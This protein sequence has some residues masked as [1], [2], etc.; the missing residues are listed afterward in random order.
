[1][2]LVLRQALRA[3]LGPAIVLALLPACRGGGPPPDP[4]A[5]SD[6]APGALPAGAQ[7]VSLLGDTLYPPALPEAVEAERRAHFRAAEE[8]LSADP[9]G[10]DALIWMGRRTAYLGRY[11]E[12]MDVFSRALEVH[13]GDPRIWR[14]RGHRQITVR[15]FDDAVADLTR[16]AELMAGRPDEVEPDGLPN[17]AGIPTS[18]LHFNVWYHLGLAHYLK[19]DFEAAAEAYAACAEASVHPD[20][21]V[22][23][24]YW[25]VMTLKRLGQ[26]EEAD[27]VLAG[28]SRDEEVIESGGY[29]ELL[30]LHKGERTA[31]ALVGPEGGDAT[32]ESTTTGYGV[33][34]WHLLSGDTTRARDIF[35]RVLAGRDQWA[36]FGYIASEAEL[37]R[38]GGR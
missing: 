26:H 17:A 18:T 9:T 14:H 23:T 16:A 10:A 30:L 2:R 32:L 34:A 3:V 19:G 33:G 4:G 8:S 36:A 38:T 28:I 21:R 25:R 20:S 12:A 22:A 31:E 7:A 6:A 35:R 1:M 5:S 13:P 15:R 11:R 29:L 24:A 27:A 37:A